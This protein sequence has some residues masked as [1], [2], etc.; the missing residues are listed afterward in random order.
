MEFVELK[1]Q[2]KTSPPHACYYCYGDDDYVISRAVSLI[3]GLA[4]EPKAFNC[5]DRIFD[6]T[7][8]AVAELMQLPLTGKYRV[9]VARG[10]TDNEVIAK[11]LKNPNQSAVL[12]LPDYIPHDSWNH[13]AAVSCPEG[14]TPLNCNRLPVKFVY[15][16]VRAITDKT[17]AKIGDKEI[18]LLYDRCGRYMTR[19][20][21]EAQKLSFLRAGD[22]VTAADIAEQVCADTEFVV[23]DLCDSIIARDGARALAIVDGMAKNNDLTAAFTLLYNR[24]KRMFTAAV[25]PDGL[26]AL[27]VKPGMATRL[28]RESDSFSKAQLKKI[29]DMLAKA[30]FAYKTG[31]MS[32]NDAL[33][34]FVAQ[35]VGRAK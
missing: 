22:T 15:P 24:F 27:G 8:D 25:S 5:A 16:F 18:E 14:A 33:T 10:K 26:A 32:V 19:I 7:D 2:L 1:K 13:S 3:C 29:L 12:V 17:N 28:K 20:S 9:V 23:Y 11:Y 30:D 34:A 6:R 21:S 35:A 4:E 31:A